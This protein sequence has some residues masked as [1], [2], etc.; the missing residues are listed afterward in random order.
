MSGVDQVDRVGPPS[1]VMGPSLDVETEL[2]LASKMGSLHFWCPR[3]VAVV[4]SPLLYFQSTVPT[5][6]CDM[7]IVF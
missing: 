7:A 1:P 3:R 4:E 5:A 6:A 2:P